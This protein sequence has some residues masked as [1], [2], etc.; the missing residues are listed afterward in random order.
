MTMA[1]MFEFS[2]DE[3]RELMRLLDLAVRQ[4]GIQAAQSALYFQ[5]KFSQPNGIRTADPPKEA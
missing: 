2:V 4:G 5:Q 3:R 1:E